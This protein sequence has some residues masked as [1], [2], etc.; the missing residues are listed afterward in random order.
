MILGAGQPS[1]GEL[2][3]SSGHNASEAARARL[4]AVQQTGEALKDLTIRATVEMIALR[5]GLL[6]VDEVLAGA[7]LTRNC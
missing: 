2:S 4:G 3:A 7:D 1:S 6:T 5:A